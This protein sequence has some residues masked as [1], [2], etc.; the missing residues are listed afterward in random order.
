MLKRRATVGA[1]LNLRGCRGDP[2]TV[3]RVHHDTLHA[4]PGNR[5]NCHSGDEIVR[6]WRQSHLSATN[7][8]TF[9]FVL[10]SHLMTLPSEDAGKRVLPAQS[11]AL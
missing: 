9:A 11:G 4:I 10:M 1:H 6:R 8:E 2:G 5:N 3:N 7:F